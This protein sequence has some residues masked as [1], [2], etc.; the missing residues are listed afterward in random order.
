[1]STH[2]RVKEIDTHG[3]MALKLYEAGNDGG[4]QAA[5]GEIAY[6]L[7]RMNLEPWTPY[8][9]DLPP[10]PPD[11]PQGAQ[12]VVETIPGGR[13]ATLTDWE[14]NEDDLQRRLPL[15]GGPFRAIAVMVD[16][17]PALGWNELP[18]P[19]GWT[20]E[21]PQPSYSA[22]Q[23]TR[24]PLGDGYKWKTDL[25][26]AGALKASSKARFTASDGEDTHGETKPFGAIHHVWYYWE[27]GKLSFDTTDSPGEIGSLGDHGEAPVFVI[28]NAAKGNPPGDKWSLG[29][30]YSV[31]VEAMED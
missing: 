8:G 26:G 6:V 3:E 5:I 21:N 31:R 10:D 28:G 20:D 29:W 22:G 11:P 7:Q 17:V 24:G 23:M 15:D 13:V 14:P 9:G 2:D 25:L 16:F 18:P 12:W 19:G 27:P 4:A 1:M 30:S